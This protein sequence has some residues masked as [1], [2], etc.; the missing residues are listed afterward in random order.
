M[1]MRVSINVQEGCDGVWSA[2]VPTHEL[3][4]L[5][6]AWKSFDGP[7]ILLLGDCAYDEKSLCIEFE[8]SSAHLLNL[9]T[10]DTAIFIRGGQ[11]KSTNALEH[12]G[13]VY[14]AKEGGEEMGIGD[15]QFLESVA[16]NVPH[17]LEISTLL[18]K[19]IRESYA[20]DLECNEKRRFTQR[21]DN[22]WAVRIQPRDKSLSITV[23]GLPNKFP[24]FK[25]IDLKVDRPPYS[26]FK[27][28][29]KEQLDAALALILQAQQH[30]RA[31]K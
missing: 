19:G 29:G 27:L 20:G 13:S 16:Q 5:G 14:G 17:L 12:N 24:D 18:L 31:K 2:S 6:K 26:R 22:F 1:A 7:S 21:P 28:K 9:G 30:L 4:A 25:G 23:H 10:T 3:S 11:D 8:M 15:K